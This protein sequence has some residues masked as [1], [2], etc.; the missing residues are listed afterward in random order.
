MDSREFQTG[1]EVMITDPEIL[2]QLLLEL[3]VPA[4]VP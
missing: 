2:A 1:H 4:T 3:P